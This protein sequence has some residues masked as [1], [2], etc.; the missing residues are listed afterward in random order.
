[1]VEVPRI[2][3]LAGERESEKVGPPALLCAARLLCHKARQ[4]S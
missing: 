3:Q 1:M 2:N 4:A